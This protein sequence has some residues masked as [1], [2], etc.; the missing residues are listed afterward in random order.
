MKLLLLFIKIGLVSIFE[1]EKKHCFDMHS[2]E[3]YL[4][5]VNYFKFSLL[6]FVFIFLGGGGGGGEGSRQGFSV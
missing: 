1:A 5:Y 4:E 6:V 3:T 2:L